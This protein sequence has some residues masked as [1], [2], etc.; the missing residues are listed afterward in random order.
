[1]LL[2]QHLGGFLLRR[3]LP[4]KLRDLHSLHRRLACPA[5]RMFRAALTSRS[6]SAPHAA[7]V[8]LRTLSGLGPSLTPHSEQTWLDGAKRP[9]LQN[10]RP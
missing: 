8:Q 10:V 2:M 5:A 3:E 1:M 6:W 9:I 4:G 7:H